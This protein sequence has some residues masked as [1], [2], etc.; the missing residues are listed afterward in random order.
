MNLRDLKY[1][2]AVG[3]L[4]H[5]GKAAQACFV[6][7]PTLSMQIKKIEDYL[8]ISIFERNN[9]TVTITAI[10]RQILK[11]AEA[12]LKSEEEL[13]ALAKLHRD[14][15]TSEIRLGIFPTL[16]PYFLPKILPV[17][18]QELP[19]LKLL[20]VEDKTEQL[21]RKLSKGKID[22]AFLAENHLEE[23]QQR[24]IFTEDF[25]LAVPENHQ[26]AGLKAVDQSQLQGMHFMLLSEEHCLR[27]QT[28]KF[29]E[30]TGAGEPESFKAT[31]LETLRQMISIGSGITLIPRIAMQPSD[32]ICYIPFHEPRPSR[33]ISM[34]WR[35]STPIG[36]VMEKL[37][38][39][40]RD[41]ADRTYMTKPVQAIDHI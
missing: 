33:T 25:L 9:K 16:A 40:T 31:S 2:V 4:K 37:Y 20:L 39:L 14:P 26:F 21:I 41:V 11:K 10:G 17:I 24:V 36:K 22:L 29:C 30:Q 18:H 8:G 28:L 3:D 7:Q 38:R 5:F 1:L 35:K 13:I 19:K 32:P 27:G 23:F 12:I 6:S 34:F 15:F